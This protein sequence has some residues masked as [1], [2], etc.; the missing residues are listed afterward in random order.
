[1][2][3]EQSINVTMTSNNFFFIQGYI[4]RNRLALD[5]VYLFTKLLIYKT[6]MHGVQD[7]VCMKT[8]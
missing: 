4:I 6:S 5:T 2:D 7:Y 1:M 3:L 8:I